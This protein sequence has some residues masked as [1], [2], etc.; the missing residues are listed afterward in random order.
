MSKQAIASKNT[1]REK[2]Y[3]TIFPQIK[4]LTEKETNLITNMA[5]T[6]AMLK[7]SLGFFWVG[8]YLVDSPQEL[9]LGP[10]QGPVACTRITKGKGVCGTCWE[11]EKT[12]IVP[13]V[14]LFP[15]HIACSYLSKSEIVLPVYINKTIKGILDIDSNQFNDFTSTDEHY[16]SKI[17]TAIF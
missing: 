13:D 17:L 14:N 7:E 2:I 15:G 3:K 6:V 10:F 9:V 8:F 5:N 11:T 4:A 12:I 1:T 16:L